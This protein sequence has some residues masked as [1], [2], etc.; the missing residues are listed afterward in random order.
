MS[1]GKLGFPALLQC[2]VSWGGRGFA[3]GDPRSSTSAAKPQR[4]S[5]LSRVNCLEASSAP[6]GAPAA[7]S[8][9]GSHPRLWLA[10][11]SSLPVVSLST[12]SQAHAQATPDLRHPCKQQLQGSED[13]GP[14]SPTSISAPPHPESAPLHPAQGQP[15]APQDAPEAPQDPFPPNQPQ[16]TAGGLPSGLGCTLHACA[17]GPEDTAHHAGRFTSNPSSHAGPPGAP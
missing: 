9:P 13:P 3:P 11:T 10:V 15:W 4:T 7:A 6:A 2:L 14:E 17:R 16:T 8:G 12:S 5:L 1:S